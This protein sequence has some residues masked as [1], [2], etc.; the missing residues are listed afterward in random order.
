MSRVPT[1]TLDT[2][3]RSSMSLNWTQ[4]STSELKPI[5][6]PG[7]STSPLAPRETRSPELTRRPMFLR[8]TCPA[9]FPRREVRVHDR[10]GRHHRRRPAYV[11]RSKGASSYSEELRS[12][13]NELTSVV[14]TPVPHRTDDPQSKRKGLALEPKGQSDLPCN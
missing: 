9:S 2:L 13:M 14:L 11:A 12:E 7:Q 5:P 8:S 4:I 1:A 10:I 3:R 6:L